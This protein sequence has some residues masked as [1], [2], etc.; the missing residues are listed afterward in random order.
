[1]SI[2]NNGHSETSIAH[3]HPKAM[4]APETKL[5]LRGV[6]APAEPAETVRFASNGLPIAV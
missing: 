5:G 4:A 3:A 1:M 6:D 2:T